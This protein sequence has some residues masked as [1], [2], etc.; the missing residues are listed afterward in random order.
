MNSTTDFETVREAKC[1]FGVGR[2]LLVFVVVIVAVAVVVAV[3][4]VMVVVIVVGVV[5]LVPVHFVHCASHTCETT[6]PRSSRNCVMWLTIRKP[7]KNLSHSEAVKQSSVF[8]LVG[9]RCFDSIPF[10]L[11]P[12]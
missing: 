4:V 2:V 8:A 5:L 11:K 3:F 12:V 6:W 1:N 7:R 9:V 10:F